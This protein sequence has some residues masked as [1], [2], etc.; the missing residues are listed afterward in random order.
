MV[1]FRPRLIES[2][3]PFQVIIVR[4]VYSSA[5]LL[6]PSSCS[7][8]LNFT[9]NLNCTLIFVGQL[10]PQN[11]NTLLFIKS[12]VKSHHLVQTLS[13]DNTRGRADR[14]TYMTALVL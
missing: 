2:S 10:K 5:L 7:V 8:S 6:V 3:R 11:S 13:L 4:L 1:L 12:F 14:R 9:A